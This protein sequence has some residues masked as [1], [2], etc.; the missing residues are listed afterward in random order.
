MV[1]NVGYDQFL[2]RIPEFRVKDGFVP[3]YETGSTRHMV[4]LPLVFG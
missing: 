2:N 3:S 1:L 4:T